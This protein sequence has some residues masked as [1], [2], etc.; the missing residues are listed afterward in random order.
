MEKIQYI[1]PTAVIGK[2][3][4]I[5]HFVVIEK[6]VTI[7]EGCIIGS[8]VVIHE[9]TRIGKGV[10]IDDN[11]VIGKSP[12]RAKRSIF[13]TEKNLDPA[14]IGDGCLIGAQVVVYRGC[15]IGS[16]VLIADSAAIRENVSVGEYTIV[17]RGVTIENLTRV[18]KKCKLETG[19]YITA[20]SEIED[21]CFIAPMVTTTNDNYLGRTEERFKH[22][23]GVHVK[24][25]GRIGANATILPGKTIGKDAVVGAGA[26]VT[27]DVP[28]RR[29]VVGAPAR[30]FGATP[31]SQLL[32]NQNWD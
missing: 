27:K 7:G 3:T 18:G 12:M 16:H 15:R 17:G 6:E 22:F 10:R 11:T 8:N 9:G 25:G 4:E 13:K 29:V 28:D 20:Y 23:K 31:E 21:Y 2:N 26:V 30:D 19:S 24:Q 5:G 32:E 14:E 1:D